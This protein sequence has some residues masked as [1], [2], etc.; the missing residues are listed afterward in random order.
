MSR[1]RK[2]KIEHYLESLQEPKPQNKKQGI[3]F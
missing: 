1:G 2:K 3:L